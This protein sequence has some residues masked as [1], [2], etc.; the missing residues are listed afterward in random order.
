MGVACTTATTRTAPSPSCRAT[1]CACSATQP[2]ANP[3]FPSAAG[4]FDSPQHHHHAAGS[5]GR[6]VH[7]LPHAGQ[8]L[9][10]RPAAAGPQHAHAAAGPDGDARH[11]QR[12]QPVPCRQ[13]GAVGGRCGDRAG[14]ARRS[15]RPHYGEVFAAA[16]RGAARVAPHRWPRW[17][18][19][20]Q[21][22]PIVR[23]TALDMLRSEAAHRHRRAHR[24][25]AR[26]RCRSA[27]RRGRQPGAAASRAARAGAGAAAEGPGARGA[28]R[29]G[30]QP[31][32]AA[33]RPVRR[34][35][36]RR[37]RRR[38]GRV[39][40]R[41]VGGAGHAGQPAEPGRGLQPTP[42]ATTW[43]KRTTSKALA[44]R[45]RLHAGARQPGAVLQRARTQC[46]C[47]AR[48]ARGPAAPAAAGRAAVFAG[49]AAGRGA[50]PAR[51]GPGAG[52]GRP[53][54]AAASARALQPTGSR[55]SSSARPSRPKPRCCRRSASIPR[56]RPCPT[57]W[58]CCTRR[59]A[60]ATR[61]WSRPKGCSSCGPAT[62][63]SPRCCSGC[64]SHRREPGRNRH[65]AGAFRCAASPACL[66]TMPPGTMGSRSGRWAPNDGA[67][68]R[69]GRRF[70]R[71]SAC[72]QPWEQRFSLR[73]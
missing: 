50:A 1:R 58:R 66:A 52:Q 9:H 63:R 49:P 4:N 30:A 16:R 29:R 21:Q 28:H 3:A 12:L 56:T 51:S 64:A 11:A 47:R 60:N 14:T 20:R 67:T 53:A 71:P 45:P 65:D 70:S 5:A 68:A 37:L 38:A 15:A 35:D 44:H 48:A 13:D 36:A 10:D 23:A 22:P 32:V 33:G 6:A 8:E 17:R 42:A 54:A 43:P 46:R 39:H 31:G 26:C 61:R 25:H 41:A 19:T 62:R 7:G 59:R 34:A 72:R 2:Q 57:H 40:R 18:P 69:N 27:R 55:C 73:I 24:R